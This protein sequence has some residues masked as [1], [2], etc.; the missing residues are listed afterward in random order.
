MKVQRKDS[1]LNTVIKHTEVNA[2]AWSPVYL[3]GKH[4]IMFAAAFMATCPATTEYRS[5]H[6]SPHRQAGIGDFRHSAKY[7]R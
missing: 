4:R 1:A 2:S 6:N 7:L 3:L 5:G